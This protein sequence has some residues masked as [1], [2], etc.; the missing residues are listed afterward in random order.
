MTLTSYEKVM[1]NPIR[2]AKQELEEDI[3]PI[4]IKKPMP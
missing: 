3:L 4:T 2:I 1:Y